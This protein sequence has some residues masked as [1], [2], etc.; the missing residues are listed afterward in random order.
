MLKIIVY[1]YII[2]CTAYCTMKIGI[3][4]LEWLCTPIQTAARFTNKIPIWLYKL[5][6]Q[7]H[8][9]AEA[10]EAAIVQHRLSVQTNTP[11]LTHTLTRLNSSTPVLDPAISIL[12]P[13]E[14]PS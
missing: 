12:A 2:C 10:S 6:F 9:Y 7:A 1:S 14:Q 13:S 5:S 3:V 4:L 11:F 8:Y